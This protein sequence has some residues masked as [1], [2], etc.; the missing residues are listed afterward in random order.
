[1]GGTIDFERSLGYNQG[2][3]HSSSATKGRTEKTIMEM[4]D[5][6]STLVFNAL[7]QL[8]QS[9]AVPGVVL[10]GNV[11]QNGN[12]AR[13]GSSPGNSMNRNYGRKGTNRNKEMMVHDEEDK[14]RKIQKE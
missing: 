14:K 5:K 7:H 4:E 3:V 9:G 1:M 10:N 2:K 12:S 8:A 11:V 6:R 13:H